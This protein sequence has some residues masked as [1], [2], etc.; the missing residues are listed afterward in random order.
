LPA[1]NFS[2]K[3]LF[4]SGNFIIPLVGGIGYRNLFHHESWMEEV[5]AKVSACSEGAFIDVGANTGQTLLKVKKVAIAG[6]YLGFEPN[7]SC[8]HYLR[9]L[10]Q[11]NGFRNA[12]I[13]PAGLS[14][15]WGMVTLSG[16]AESEDDTSASTIPGFR[17]HPAWSFPAPVMPLDDV[18]QL[19]TLEKIGIIKIDA[20]GAEEKVIGGAQ[21]VIGKFRPFVLCEILPV[22]NAQNKERE[23]RQDR[24]LEL[25]GILDYKLYRII[26]TG[27]SGLHYFKRMEAIT[28]H[29]DCNLS[30]Y[31]FIPAEQVSRAEK[32]LNLR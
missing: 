18:P 13:I 26:K 9:K 16:Y 14:D 23:Q 15:A 12:Q 10:I 24:L 11:V 32:H 6:L 7:P 21:Q 25:L 2:Y 31:L 29:E 1:L 3:N 28:M 4:G 17:E 19:R 22:Y 30:D 27:D 8:V 20:E 5:I